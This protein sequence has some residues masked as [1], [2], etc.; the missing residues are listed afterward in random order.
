MVSGDES[1][2]DDLVRAFC[3]ASKPLAMIA[4]HAHG[5]E[6]FER[7]ERGAEQACGPR[8]RTF[9]VTAGGGGPRPDD[10]R[11]PSETGHEDRYEGSAPLPFHFLWVEEKADGLSVSV[12]G[13]DRGRAKFAKSN[14]SSC[15]LASIRLPPQLRHKSFTTFPQ[16]C[17][18][19]A[20][21][22]AYSMYMHRRFEAARPMLAATCCLVV[23]MTLLLARIVHTQHVLFAFLAFNLALAAVPFA[24]SLWAQRQQRAGRA[25]L[26]LAVLPVWLLFFPNAPYLVSDFVHLRPRPGVP[27]WY[28]AVM[29]A[30]FAAAGMALGVGSLMRFHRLVE[31]RAG[32][33]V[34]WLFVAGSCG[35]AGLGV[36]LGRFL[37]WNSWDVFV[38]PG[39]VFADVGA[40]LI[41]PFGHPRSW[42]VALVF[43]GLVWATY[44]ACVLVRRRDPRATCSSGSPTMPA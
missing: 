13:L 22:S 7:F 26:A 17:E 10:L 31:E 19:L 30:S 33:S 12:I 1:V 35:L 18:W 21:A 39:A 41:D 23:P 20:F 28:D 34:G 16:R 6:R 43:G 44:V 37:R 27:L 14:V 38:S 2:R 9:L 5:Y 32:R 24:L 11:D 36:Y 25:W 8:A 15:L 29:L 4:G 3:G 40:R 42:A